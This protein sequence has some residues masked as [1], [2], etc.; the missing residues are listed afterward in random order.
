VIVADRARNVLVKFGKFT[1]APFTLLKTYGGTPSWSTGNFNNPTDAAVIYHYWQDASGA[2]I[3]EGL[4]YLQSVEQWTASTGGQLHHLGV[5]ADELVATPGQCDATLTFLLTAY[6]DYAVRVVNY[7]TATVV[8]SWTRT[9]VSSGRKSEYWNASGSPAGLYTWFVDHRNAYG[10]ETQW[11]TSTGPSFNLN[12]FT[13]TASVPDYVSSSGTYALNGSSNQPADSWTWERDGSPWSGGQNSSVYIPDDPGAT[14]AINWRLS[15]RRTSDGLWDSD[16]RSTYV[17][18]PG[19]PPPPPPE[20]PPHCDEGPVPSAGTTYVLTG[21][22]RRNHHLGSGT[23]IGERTANEPRVVQLYSFVGHHERRGEAWPNPLAGDRDVLEEGGDAKF[24]A[25]AAF[26]HR[27]LAP[28]LDA[29]RM[30]VATQRSLG[31]DRYIGLALDPELGARPSDDLL[32]IDAESGLIWITDP[33]SGAIGY[34]VP[35]MPSGARVAVRQFSNRKDA[36]RPD[37]VTDSAA[38]AEMSASSDAL[39][40]KPGDVRLLI[41]IGPL[42]P[43]TESADVGLVMLTAPSLAAL[44]ER[45]A[46][47]PRSVLGL[48]ANDTTP[49]G[50]IPAITRFRLTQAPPDPA[51]PEGVRAISLALAP[52]LLAPT[53][54][55][56]AATVDRGA[57]RDAVRRY[58]ITALAFTVPDGSPA[59]VKIR[60]Y[61][62]VGRLVRTL[63]DDMYSGGAYR[64]QWDMKDQ[65]GSRV[66]PGV[67]VAI[68]EAQGF[69]AMTRLVVVP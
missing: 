26:M 38:Y 59:I 19:P 35:E 39:T 12:C 46:D 31:S 40:G 21:P 15:A 3:Q 8:A 42:S 28:G 47:A 29:Y 41:A 63:V 11:R 48:F 50:G 4:P 45:V 23:W 54:S 13:V 33:D 27:P 2:L 17:S 58:G 5:D 57:L 25:R 36:W 30:R 56:T 67:Y 7:G 9:G 32:G 53:E 22:T 34:L 62:P 60:V 44:R 51:A 49:L 69:R 10:D 20:C 1:G 65:R 66:A 6:G 24:G 43:G 37:P 55:A 61:D 68:M 52:G 18:I 64:A 14:Y 16:A